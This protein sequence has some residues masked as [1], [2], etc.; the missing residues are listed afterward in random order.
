M[1]FVGATSLFQSFRFLLASHP[2][3]RCACPWL[4]QV[5]PLAHDTNTP[6]YWPLAHDTKYPGLLQVGPL[7]HDTNIWFFEVGLF[8]N[9][10]LE[11]AD[12]P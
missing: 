8:G 7:A 11:L 6:G 1:R 3:R 2:G 12:A 9:F 5:G 10:E 4:S